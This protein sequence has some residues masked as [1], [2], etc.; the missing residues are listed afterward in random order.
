MNAKELPPT[1]RPPRANNHQ[2]D[3][4]VHRHQVGDHAAAAEHA[5]ED[6]LAHGR[7][8]AVGPVPVVHPALDG[9][10]EGREYWK[11]MERML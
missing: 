4:S 11:G 5:A 10:A 6:A 9:L 1:M 7:D 2:V 8:D 3:H